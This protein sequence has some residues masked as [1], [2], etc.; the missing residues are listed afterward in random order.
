[1]KQMDGGMDGW[2]DGWNS[3]EMDLIS[4]M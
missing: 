3:N 2:M 4:W 1:M